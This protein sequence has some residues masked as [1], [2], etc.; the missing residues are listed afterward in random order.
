MKIKYTSHLKTR[1]QLRGYDESLPRIIFK[2]SAERYFDTQT[3]HFIAV[4]E[5]STH[6]HPLAISYDDF[7]T[8]IEIVTIHPIPRKQISN[9]VMTKRWK[10]L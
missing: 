4:K 5:L 2:E 10:P 9:R 1:I 8:Y 3:Q 6:H 7:E